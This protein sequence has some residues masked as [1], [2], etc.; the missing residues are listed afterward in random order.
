MAGRGAEYRIPIDRAVSLNEAGHSIHPRITD[1][2]GF[3]SEE[4]GD[5]A[6]DHPAPGSQVSL[7]VWPASVRC[8]LQAATTRPLS[9]VG[10]TQAICRS[11]AGSTR[12]SATSRPAST[13][14]SMASTL[15]RSP[16]AALP[17]PAPASAG[18]SRWRRSPNGSPM[19]SASVCLAPKGISGSRSLMGNQLSTC[20]LRIFSTFLQPWGDCIVPPAP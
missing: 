15:K 5:W 12:C 10:S 19:Q 20:F 13:A 9:L 8:P 16:F 7:I 18:A 17:A 4:I 1:V 6:R 14:P 3:S 2:T 11:S